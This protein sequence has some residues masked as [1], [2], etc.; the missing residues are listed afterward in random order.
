MVRSRGSPGILGRVLIYKRGINLL[1]LLVYLLFLL[2]NLHEKK[3]IL[4]QRVGVGSSEP[5]HCK[6]CHVCE[7][8]FTVDLSYQ[9]CDAE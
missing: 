4:S 2:K 8:V 9:K 7:H 3:I 5:R 1:N 6:L